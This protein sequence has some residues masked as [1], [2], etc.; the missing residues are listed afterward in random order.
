MSILAASRPFTAA[1]KLRRFLGKRIC[2]LAFPFVHECRDINVLD[3]AAEA[4]SH[5][6]PFREKKIQ[7]VPVTTSI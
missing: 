5:A 2:I 3:P 7:S 6:H 4:V 1:L